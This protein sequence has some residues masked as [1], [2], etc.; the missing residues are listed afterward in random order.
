MHTGINFRK[1]S[2][3]IFLSL[4]F[5]VVATTNQERYLIDAILPKVSSMDD[6]QFDQTDLEYII[7]KA[8]LTLNHE[9]TVL[10]RR[11]L[12]KLLH[13]LVPVTTISS[14]S[15]VATNPTGKISQKLDTYVPDA[16]TANAVVYKTKS[17][18]Q[19]LQNLSATS[20]LADVENAIKIM[21]SGIPV[22]GQMPSKLEDLKNQL[23]LFEA[24]GGAKIA[25]I[26]VAIAEFE[27]KIIETHKLI[28]NRQ[29]YFYE[30]SADGTMYIFG[31]KD[32]D[33]ISVTATIRDAGGF[34]I[35]M[36]YASKSNINALNKIINSSPNSMIFLLKNCPNSIAEVSALL[37]QNTRIS[38]SQKI[39]D[40]FSSNL[41]FKN[42]FAKRVLMV[43]KT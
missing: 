27:E 35:S 17:F 42:D 7:D 22:V 4:S 19:P 31:G 28:N 15:D 12:K 10:A 9:K 33:R 11:E 24:E 21:F 34:Y 23:K 37:T 3:I 26:L 8:T 16:S 41:G 1:L 43:G 40:S 38:I 29:P 32:K 25:D 18:F 14:M 2:I 5:C 39:F 6:V 30:E 13:A 20:N 36:N